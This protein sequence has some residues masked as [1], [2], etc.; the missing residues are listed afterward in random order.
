MTPEEL[1][2][3]LSQ[4]GPGEAYLATQGAGTGS[5]MFGFDPVSA[6]LSSALGYTFGIPS[7]NEAERAKLRAIEQATVNAMTAE[8]KNP[9]ETY[10]VGM[11]DTSQ[12]ADLAGIP[13]IGTPE[14]MLRQTVSTVVD[15]YRKENPEKVEEEFEKIVNPP[16]GVSGTGG[17]SGVPAGAD[18]FSPRVESTI[19]TPEE[20]F[21]ELEKE[22]QVA[23]VQQVLAN[24][25]DATEEQIKTVIEAYDIPAEVL[26][27][28]TGQ[29]SVKGYVEKR[30]AAPD[31]KDTVVSWPRDENGNLKA[32]DLPEGWVYPNER[33][34]KDKK[35]I[36][37]TTHTNPDGSTVIVETDAEGNR[38]ERWG[39]TLPDTEIETNTSEVLT[40]EERK[41]AILDWIKF[42]PNVTLDVL[43]TKM[44]NKGVTDQDIIDAT[45]KTPEEIAGSGDT[46]GGTPIITTPGTPTV[47]PIITTT[48]IP[49]NTP[50]GTPTGTDTGTPT[51]TDT[52]NGDGDGNGNGEG[53]GNG[54]GMLFAALSPTRTTDTVIPVDLF[55]LDKG[56]PL[57][58]KLTEY[59]PPTSPEQMMLQ[60]ISQRQQQRRY[61]A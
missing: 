61:M 57:V 45:G 49:P 16:V 42:N 30:D 40:P 29:D 25:P 24:N 46:G 27:E 13:T 41:Q 43:R 39:N 55:K 12:Y 38:Y 7:R 8:G 37:T 51:G 19:P 2:A 26:T 50:T 36:S 23:R 54:N 28:A 1:L 60:G 33:G 48:G 17:T 6:V 35:I 20:T 4:A 18:I 53:N 9:Y 34:A 10:N 22:Q 5:G 58:T 56:I 14:E 21:K 52:G 44:K 11:F 47:P 32:T 3:Q 59:V 31:T 15:A